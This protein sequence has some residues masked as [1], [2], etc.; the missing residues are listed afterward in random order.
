MIDLLLTRYARV[1]KYQDI[2]ATTR[3]IDRILLWEHYVIPQWYKNKIYVAHRR[4]LAHPPQQNLN[5]F[6]ASVWWHSD[7]ESSS[8]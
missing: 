2:I 5:W 6:N 1:N 8:K 3:A 7:D 4:Y